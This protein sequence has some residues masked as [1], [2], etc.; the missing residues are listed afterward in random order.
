MRTDD[1]LFLLS[2]FL[3]LQCVQR[4]QLRSASAS[5]NKP[6]SL[7]HVDHVGNLVLRKNTVNPVVAPMVCTF[8]S[9]PSSSVNLCLALVVF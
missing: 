1:A 9:P 3:R 4:A 8:R 2:A 5:E 7:N 6:K